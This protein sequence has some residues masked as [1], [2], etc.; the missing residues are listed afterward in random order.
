MKNL[1]LLMTICFTLNAQ[2]GFGDKFLQ[3]LNIDCS[4]D[5][6]YEKCHVAGTIL[7]KKVKS[8]TSQCVKGD[9]YGV[10]ILGGYVWVDQGCSV[11]VQLKGL[12]LVD[13]RD[14]EKKWYC[15][16]EGIT[17]TFFGEAKKKIEAQRKAL[18]KCK[19]KYHSMHCEIVSCVQE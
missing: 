4:S 14:S 13:M 2:A 7:K 5:G 17:K 16:A 12:N 3:K 10:D 8:T 11:R 19:A 15:T 18:N 1:F 6:S 9:N